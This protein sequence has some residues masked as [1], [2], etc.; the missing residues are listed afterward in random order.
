MT[1]AGRSD[2]ALFLSAVAVLGL[3]VTPLVHAEEHLREEHEA[4]SIAEAWRA[5]STDPLDG[6]AFALEHVHEAQRPKPGEEHGHGDG[7]GHQ[8]GHSHGPGR[9]GSGALAHLSVALH[10]AP[11][12]PEVAIVTPEH[13]APAA[14]AAQLRGT[15]RYLVPE[16]S[17]GPPIGR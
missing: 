11:Q 15:I 4:E 3:V 5:G 2:R 17:Q 8:Q 9:H 14:F 10:S 13:C 16:W 7:D 12:L 6:L 1:C